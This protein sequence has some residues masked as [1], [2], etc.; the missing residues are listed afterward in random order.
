MIYHDT[1]SHRRTHGTRLTEHGIIFQPECAPAWDYTP[2][3]PWEK[4]R[5]YPRGC[6]VTYE[7]RT[8]V[9]C[10][11]GKRQ[12]PTHSRG[13]TIVWQPIDRIGAPWRALAA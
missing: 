7:G 5:T 8:Y 10:I 4:G 1:A 13:R 3:E 11:A 9:A 6:V 12:C 2:G